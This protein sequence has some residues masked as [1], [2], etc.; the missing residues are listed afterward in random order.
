MAEIRIHDLEGRRLY[1]D[2]GERQLFL[3]EAK[4]QSTDKR[5]FAVT[6]MYLGCRLSEALEI[7]P[8]RINLSNREITIR[9]LK[10]R[11]DNQFRQVPAPEA[12]IDALSLAFDIR[13]HQLANSTRANQRLWTWTRQH[14]YEIIKKI[15]IDAGIPEGKHRTPKG[16]RH[17]YGINAIINGV[18][19]INLKEWMGHADLATTQ[20]YTTVIGHEKKEVAKRM[21]RELL[22]Q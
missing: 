13:K 1:L 20:I 15:M 6:L 12:L 22:K 5:T 2:Q 19:V 21:W 11:K 10:K 17:S 14:A 16:L 18:D 3:E 8:N 7:T 9:S 4:K